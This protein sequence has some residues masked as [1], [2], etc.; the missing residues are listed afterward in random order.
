MSIKRITTEKE[1]EEN[2]KKKDFLADIE[3][4]KN[5]LSDL[6][7]RIKKLEKK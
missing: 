1:R 4:I 5:Y 6:E 2:K 3:Y 7:K